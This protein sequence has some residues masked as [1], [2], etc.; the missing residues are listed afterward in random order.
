MLLKGFTVTVRG[1]TDGKPPT[2]IG[3]IKLY[4]LLEIQM[5]SSDLQMDDKN[6][7]KNAS[8]SVM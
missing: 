8:E 7:V 3:E 5:R 6:I 4:L 2:V 1:T